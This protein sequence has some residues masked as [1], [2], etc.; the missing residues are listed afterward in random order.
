ML[1]A[2]AQVIE[3]GPP[4]AQSTHRE[5]LPSPRPSAGLDGGNLC[6]RPSSRN[7]ASRGATRVTVSLARQVD[8]APASLRSSP[9][10]SGRA[11]AARLSHTHRLCRQQLQESSTVGPGSRLPR[12]PVGLRRSDPSEERGRSSSWPAG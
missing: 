11:V 9:D 4:P 8:V 12:T 7:L 5:R 3:G 2:K 1:G 10:T 6:A